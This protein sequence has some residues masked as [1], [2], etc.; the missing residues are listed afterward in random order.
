MKKTARFWMRTTLLIIMLGLLIFT[1]YQAVSQKT[2]SK[3]EVGDEA[4]N[5]TLT[6]ISGKEVSLN[7][8]K[9]KAVMLNFW[10]TWC[11]PCRTE[12]PAL[13]KAF[14]KYQKQG[15]VVIGINI[16]E[17]DIAA[18]DFARRYGLKF[19]IWMDRDR[20]VVQLY[21]IGPI[22]STLF[23][24]PEGVITYFKDGALSLNQ[25]ETQILPILPKTMK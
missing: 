20:E 12:M 17:T 13:Q 25:L 2:G 5:F 19:P 4:P 24:N 6:D 11:E 23:I 22:P 15:F 1:L 14:D 8:L 18:A 10:G 7:E 9:G 21:H 3:P 16:A